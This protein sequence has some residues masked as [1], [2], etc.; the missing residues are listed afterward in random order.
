MLLST[1]ETFQQ[2]VL[3][4]SLDTI[5]RSFR[6]GHQ[7][8]HRT[9][10]QSKQ[11]PMHRVTDCLTQ[12]NSRGSIHLIRNCVNFI[13]QAPHRKELESELLHF[14]EKGT[15]V[16]ALAELQG[17]TDLTELIVINEMIQGEVCGRHSAKG[18][19]FCTSGHF[20]RTISRKNKNVERK[21]QLMIC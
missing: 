17:N 18:R 20:A 13:F 3:Q 14:Q 15:E 6:K 9:H 1:S 16:D 12:I 5:K 11:I 7:K 10:W 2:N 21:A 19:S 8:S 4:E